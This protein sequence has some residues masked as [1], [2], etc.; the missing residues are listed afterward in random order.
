MEM[1]PMDLGRDGENYCINWTMQRCLPGS[2]HSFL[3]LVVDG[4]T[5]PIAFMGFVNER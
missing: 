5:R 1:D 2:N 4:V 3:S